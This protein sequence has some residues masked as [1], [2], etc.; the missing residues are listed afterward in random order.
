MFGAGGLRL[1]AAAAC[2]WSDCEGVASPRPP[3]ASMATPAVASRRLGGR[4]AA[5]PVFSTGS[6][7]SARAISRRSPSAPGLPI[8]PR[9]RL[10]TPRLQHTV[11]V[12]R[13]LQDLPPAQAVIGE[14]PQCY[15]TTPSTRACAT[16]GALWSRA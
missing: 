15:P 3:A 10:A 5:E 9:V 12:D 7:R 2:P 4:D 14:V 16:S 13:I 11:R 6:M 1:A 8:H